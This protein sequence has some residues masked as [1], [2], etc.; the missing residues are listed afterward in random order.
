MRMSSLA[1]AVVSLSLVPVSSAHATEVTVVLEG[2]LTT[3]RN[4]DGLSAGM[5]F[6]GTLSYDSAQAPLLEQGGLAKYRPYHFTLAVGGYT[7]VED[8]TS[9]LDVAN[10]QWY[11][12]ALMTDGTDL[13]YAGMSLLYSDPATF[14]S[15]ALPT[16]VPETGLRESFVAVGGGFVIGNVTTITTTVAAGPADLVGGLIGS[17]ADANLAATIAKPLGAKLAGAYAAL[18]DDPV[19]TNDALGAL[20]AFVNQVA[21]QRGKAILPAV[22]DALTADAKAIVR[23]LQ[24]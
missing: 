5:P 9:L 2:T 19:R 15:S 24:P 4:Y 18:N 6:V 7:F 17:V 3:A 8:P 21:A 22:A 23:L 1:P 20:G 16:V 10:D 12:D 13:G 11:G 14:P